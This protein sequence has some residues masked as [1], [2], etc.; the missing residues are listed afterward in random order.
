MHFEI[1]FAGHREVRKYKK[2]GGQGGRR[3]KARA[4]GNGTGEEV[5]EPREHRKSRLL[6]DCPSVASLVT[7]VLVV[8]TGLPCK[9]I[10]HH[11]SCGRSFRELSFSPSS[12]PC[13]I[14]WDFRGHTAPSQDDRTSSQAQERRSLFAQLCAPLQLSTCLT[15]RLSSVPILAP[16]QAPSA[17]S[18]SG[19]SP[20]SAFLPLFYFISSFF[21]GTQGSTPKSASLNQ[22]PDPR[23]SVLVT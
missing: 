7:R 11:S 15:A 3:G 12:R 19:S 17:H 6:Q 16:P 23:S 5:P 14:D 8:F 20:C 21:K 13:S 2:K 18:H 4:A 9:C 10:A 1:N 22:E